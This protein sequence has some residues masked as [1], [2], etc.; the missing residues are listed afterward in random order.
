MTM[1]NLRSAKNIDF[2]RGDDLYCVKKANKTFDKVLNRHR[3]AF[4]KTAETDA[5]HYWLFCY[6]QDRVVKSY[7]VTKEVFEK[8]KT[9]KIYDGSSKQDQFLIN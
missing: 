7:L 5:T 1:D 9:F 6:D 8:G 2:I 3:W 4:K